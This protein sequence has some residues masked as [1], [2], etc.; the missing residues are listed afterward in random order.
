MIGYA[1]VWTGFALLA[2]LADTLTSSMRREA[3][4]KKGR[5]VHGPFFSRP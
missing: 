5:L 2:F 4:G 1:M 3:S